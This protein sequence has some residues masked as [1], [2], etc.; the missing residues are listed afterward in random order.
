MKGAWITDY[1]LLLKAEIPAGLVEMLHS[2]VNGFG[3]VATLSATPS[4]PRR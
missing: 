3:I 4:A 1:L 2:R